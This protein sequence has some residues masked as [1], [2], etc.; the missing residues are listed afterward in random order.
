MRKTALQKKLT[1][2]SYSANGKQTAARTSDFITFY[3]IL[4][5]F[6]ACLRHGPLFEFVNSSDYSRLINS[7]LL[8]RS[9]ISVVEDNEVRSKEDSTSKQA[10]VQLVKKQPSDF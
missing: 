6:E 1:L 9:K 7:N 10:Q 4:E 3:A 5:L 2:N 8:Q